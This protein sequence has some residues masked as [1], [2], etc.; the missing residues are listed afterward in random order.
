MTQFTQRF[1][2]DIATFSLVID[3]DLTARWAVELCGHIAE[4]T[5]KD[6]IEFGSDW[7]LRALEYPAKHTA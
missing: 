6:W 2:N 1:R 4:F 3:D 7:M 5:C